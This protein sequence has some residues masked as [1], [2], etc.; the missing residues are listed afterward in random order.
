MSFSLSAAVF[1]ARGQTFGWIYGIDRAQVTAVRQRSANQHPMCSFAASGYEKLA[2]DTLRNFAG[3]ASLRYSL[4]NNM[5]WTCFFDSLSCG[6]KRHALH[7][8]LIS[9]STSFSDW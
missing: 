3:D 4:R 5:Q 6:S 8:T 9:Y 2:F 7:C 1:C